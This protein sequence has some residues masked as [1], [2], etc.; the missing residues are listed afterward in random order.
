MKSPLVFK[1]LRDIRLPLFLVMLLLAGF[2]CFW[3]KFTERI[4][5]Q[6]VPFFMGLA[7]SKNIS[8]FDVEQTL[9]Q[10][11]A[12]IVRTLIGGENI[13][14]DRAMSVLSIGYVHPLMQAVF[15]IW[16]VGRASGALAGEIDRGTMELLLAQPVRRS[17]VVLAHLCIDLLTIPLLSLALWGGTGLGTWLVGPITV[18]AA[19]LK[20]FP[21]VVPLD[22]HALEVYPASFGPALWNVGA[23]LFAISGYTMWLSAAGRFRWKVLGIAIFITLLQ[24]LINLIGQLWDTLAWLRP[25]TVFYYY[26]PQQIILQNRWTVDLG[27]TWTGGQH[28]FSVNV[29]AVLLGVG[30][31]GYALA[32][33]TF[34]RRDLPAPL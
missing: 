12:K 5:G 15:A 17:R 16:A 23:L 14:L 26:Q 10:G 25:F 19:D 11:P 8:A 24:F 1:L 27:A 32:F 18:N 21:L 6:L 30:C 22:P 31:A 29:L 4:T 2:Q 13:S 9:F 28:L 20:K 34:C 33:W 3:V 7:A